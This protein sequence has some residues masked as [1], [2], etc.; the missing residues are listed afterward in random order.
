MTRI[1]Q[2]VDAKT[3]ATDLKAKL[4]TWL[5]RVDHVPARVSV[6]RHGRVV[7]ALVPA[8]DLE[9]LWAIDALGD[10]L[11]GYLR[12]EAEREAEAERRG[13]DYAPLFP[14]LL[15]EARAQAAQR[16]RYAAPYAED[17][18]DH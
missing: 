2:T 4:S 13:V 11:Q 15:R 12:R 6:T 17:E 14:S 9:M 3:T 7:A 18:G 16:R 10:D 5:H 8:R 1:V